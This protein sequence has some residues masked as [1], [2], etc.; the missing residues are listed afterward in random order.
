MRDEWN[1]LLKHSE[2]DTIFLRWEWLYNWWL[3][4]GGGSNQLCIILVK[5]NHCLLGIAPLYIKRRYLPL[6]RE[7]RFLGSNVVCSD[8]LNFI[9]FKNR[10]REAL[11]SILCYIEKDKY[12]WDLLHLTDI[13]S[14]SGNIPLM[15]SFFQH[16]RV[17]IN[18]RYT[19]CPFIR[20]TAT[21][22]TIYASFASIMKN[23]IKRK[24]KKFD[25][26]PDS[27]FQELSSDA[28]LCAHFSEFVHLNKLSLPRRKVLSP[29][30]HTDF[31]TF[32]Y[33][34]L[35]VLNE[36]GMAKLCF[37]RVGDTAIAGIYLLLYRNKVCYYQSGFDPAWGK[38]SPGTLLM[39]HCIKSAYEGGA[40][41]F[42]FLQGDEEYKR[43][44]TQRKRTSVKITI[45]SS[46]SKGRLL[47]H[48]DNCTNKAKRFYTERAFPKGL[49]K[50]QVN[51][52]TASRTRTT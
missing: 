33:N 44:W 46:S 45:Y 27:C 50:R 13:P 17:A 8:Y 11:Y 4:Y 49:G 19:V 36:K 52:V 24:L 47:S 35:R 20:L 38:A 10:E 30:L 37:L 40:S 3:V 14:E 51:F 16:N 2:M 23:T 31:L 12:S 1:E 34:I 39:Y 6:F 29:F 41:E 42:D 26:I 22:E 48:I 21:W 7:V 28:E 32:H 43:N 15:E 25:R 5:E 18:R 9:L